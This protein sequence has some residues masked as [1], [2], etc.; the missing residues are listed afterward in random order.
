MIR[1]VLLDLDDTLFDFHKSEALAVAKTLET[2]G[3]RV[4]EAIVRRYSAIN[5][6]QWERLERGEM[7]REEVKLR[8]FE[9]LYE[10]L[11]V[12]ISARETQVVYEKN[13]SKGHIF[14]DGAE[15]LVRELSQKYELYVISNGTLPVQTGRIRSAGIAPYFRG[16]FISEQI[17][18]V[19]PQ[20]EFFDACFA[21]IG[22]FDREEAV[23]VGDS[24]TSDILGGIHAG[25][26]TIRFCPHPKEGER[27]D[28]V[29]DFTVRTLAEIPPL[30]ERL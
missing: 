6:A 23:V 5:Q 4:T 9:I 27:T 2:F 15:E 10:E 16:I 3:V 30:L 22:N 19:K 25:V 13:L 11:G 24:L 8:R 26:R 17:G 14:I 12:D 28:I 7:T 18:F 29:P 1:F 21:K 20:K